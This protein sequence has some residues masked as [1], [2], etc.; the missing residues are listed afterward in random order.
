MTVALESQLKSQPTAMDTRKVKFSK[1]IRS[2][3]FPV[4]L[5]I[6]PIFSCEL[7]PMPRSL[8]RQ[9]PDSLF[10][11]DSI[12]N[13]RNRGQQGPTMPTMAERE[14]KHEQR[15]GRNGQG[16]GRVRRY[17]AED[18]TGIALWRTSL[19]VKVS[20]QGQG[21]FGRTLPKTHKTGADTGPKGSTPW[22]PLHSLTLF[23]PMTLSK[24]RKR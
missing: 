24:R 6:A 7:G 2:I 15:H 21:S 4:A 10:H 14:K 19:G 1:E 20:R 5:F 12:E 8:T 3:L 11:F 16:A 22:S 17:N 13:P 18:R 23:F 9:V